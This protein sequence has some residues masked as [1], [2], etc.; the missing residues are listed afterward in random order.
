MSFADDLEYWGVDELYLESCCQH[1]YDQR[2]EGLQDELRKEAESILQEVDNEEEFTGNVTV[3]RWQRKVWDLLEKPQTS[4]S[5]R[6]RAPL[7]LM[8]G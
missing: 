2:K 1:K 6:E 5:A 7:M 3:V 8:G 4:L